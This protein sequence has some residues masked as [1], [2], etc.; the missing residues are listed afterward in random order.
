MLETALPKR[1]RAEIRAAIRGGAN[2]LAPMLTEIGAQRVALAWSVFGASAARPTVILAIDQA[3][4]LF[5][6]DGS[7][8]AEALLTLVRDLA[9]GRE[10]QVITIFAIR[11]DS[12]DALQRAGPLEGLAQSALPL[13]PLPRRAYKDVIEGPARRF[14]YAGGKL[15]IEPQL[16]ERLL[17]DLERG[18]GDALPLL[19]FTLEQLFL[20]Y[21]RS[22]ALRLADYE[23]FGELRGAIDAAV[24]RA[25]RR[26]DTDPRVP[27]DRRAREALLRRGLIPWLAGI[28]PDTKSPRRNIARRS[29]IPEEARP[30]IDLLVEERLLSTDTHMIA[31]DETGTITRVAT[32]EPAHEA[33]LRQWGLLEGW[34]AEDLGLLATLEGIRRAA[35]DWEANGMAEAWLAHQGLRLAEARALD[36]RPD[37]AA[38]LDE[39]DRAYIERCS[40][41]DAA[42]IAEREQARANELAR[43]K[44]EAERATAQARYSRQLTRIIA[45][46][47]G[48]FALVAIAAAVLGLIAKREATRAEESYRIARDAADSLVVDI[49]QGLRAVEGMPTASVRRILDTAKG[50]VERLVT[51]APDDL[52]LGKSR[53]L[54]QRQFAVNYTA[55]GDLARALEF[56]QASVAG[57]RQILAARPNEDSM[58][59]LA[60]SLLRVGRVD[61][62]RGDANGARVAANE[63]LDLAS[64]VASADKNKITSDQITARALLLL[65]DIE[66][67]RGDIERG[68][69]LAKAAVATIRPLADAAPS[70]QPLQ[71]LLADT[72]ERLGNIFGGVDHRHDAPEPARSVASD[73]IGR[74]RPEGGARSLP[75]ERNNLQAP[76]GGNPDRHGSSQPPRKHSHPHGAISTWRWARS[77]TLWLRT[78]RRLRSAAN[79]WLRIPATPTGSAESRSITTNSILSGWRRATTMMRW[80][81]SGMH[82][83]SHRSCSTST[84]ATSL[85]GATSA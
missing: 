58:V 53:V 41:R 20:E 80:R 48:V 32:I 49:A 71:T 51:A 55:I 29:D 65:S 43:A 45:A 42:A 62:Q 12:Y 30:L 74:H 40:A 19:A 4:E 85:G 63:A 46:A 10:Q 13:L 24:G 6:A 27:K 1:T 21:R 2:Q 38:Q 69:E 23:E 5:R 54:M 16:T 9:H 7:E 66:V 57:A 22:G 36:A 50:V 15:T 52:D 61:E 82:S 67:A 47:A 83:T 81:K 79:F 73:G 72:L 70:D 34:I 31:E 76:F 37:L 78:S 26:A 84:R 60:D 68:L 59:T 25:F 28:D 56:G 64:K 33:L 3:E 18:G 77:L 75:V 39:R 14:A 8:Q 44:A 11:S 17:E 35:R